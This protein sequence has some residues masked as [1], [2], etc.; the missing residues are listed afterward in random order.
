MK[1][2]GKPDYILM[3]IVFSLVSIGMLMVYG[4][5]SVKALSIGGPFFY[6]KR[7][8]FSLCVGAAALFVGYRVKYS[9]YSKYSLQIFLVSLF[10]LFLVRVPGMG[11]TLLGGTRWLDIFGFSFQPSELMKISLINIII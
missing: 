5:S 10:F 2:E 1:G 3:L 8:L 6:G 9:E 11:Q 4:A 7:H